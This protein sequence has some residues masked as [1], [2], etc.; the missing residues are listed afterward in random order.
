VEQSEW[1]PQQCIVPDDDGQDCQ[2]PVVAAG[3]CDRHYQRA[4][5][6]SE[7]DEGL[8][9]GAVK[10]TVHAS[11][12]LA[13]RVAEAAEQGGVSQSEWMR[14]VLEFQFEEGA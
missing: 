1:S 11:A 9:E 6:G 13:G 14:E 2:R 7:V 4:R 3:M 10:L 5:R 8:G 12:E